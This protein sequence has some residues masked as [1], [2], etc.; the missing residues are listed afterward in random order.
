MRD[1]T[2]V[3]NWNNLGIVA[4]GGALP[5]ALANAAVQAG[6][7]VRI[8][9]LTDFV[10]QDWAGFCTQSFA[11]E[12][13]ADICAY[14]QETGV[15]AVSFAGNVRRPDFKTFSPPKVDKAS[16]DLLSS[17]AK[18]GDDPLLRSVISIFEGAGF[19]VIGVAQIAPHF[20][21]AAGTF[22]AHPMP[23]ACRV[24]AQLAL[25]IAGKMGALD[26]GQGVVVSNGVVLAVEAQEG[27]QA[28]LERCELL[29]NVLRGTPEH[30]F[31]VF[32]KCAKPMQDRRID[33]PVIGVSTI[34]RVAK[35]GLA[36]LIL[37]ANAVI[38]LE[39]EAVKSAVDQYGLF[40]YSL[41]MPSG[42]GR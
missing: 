15:Q 36:G 29:P 23:D 21:A 11:L 20:L 27:T 39:P 22:G 19:A 26:I 28:M 17:A 5:L 14:F 3:K 16:I 24:D 6:K 41:A 9:C 42:D 12:G 35:A 25:D 40:L 13:I 7:N 31:G 37:E 30:R 10:D 2:Q 38:I 8:A 1:K 34:D 33:L 4:G 32:A 18:R